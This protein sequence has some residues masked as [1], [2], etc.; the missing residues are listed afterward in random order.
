MTHE[1]YIR[2]LESA[3]ENETEAHAFYL[4]AS[5]A[6]QDAAL[7]GIFSGLAEEELKHKALLQGYLQGTEALRFD[8]TVDYHVSDTVD[9][10]ILS[11]AM[12]FTDAVALAMKKEEEAMALYKAFADASPDPAQ[13]QVFL[14]LSKMEAGH[15][16]GLE[17]IFLNAACAE[18]W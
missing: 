7:K 15:K 8:E 10:P 9:A 11:T 17:E 12:S 3:V 2:I 16:A 6:A 5:A 14:E 18:A 13:R 4:S 1:A